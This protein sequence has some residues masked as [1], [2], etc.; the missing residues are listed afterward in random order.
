MCIA[1]FAFEFGSRDE[2]GHRI[3]D[4]HVESATPNQCIRDFQSFFPIIGL[5]NQQLFE[6]GGAYAEGKMCLKDPV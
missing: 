6:V 5:G 3:D 2:C 4:N 1:H